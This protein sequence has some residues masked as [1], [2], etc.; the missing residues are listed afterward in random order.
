MVSKQD[1]YL[2]LSRFTMLKPFHLLE[3]C[4]W[5]E[6]KNESGEI[7]VFVAFFHLQHK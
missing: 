2:N 6:I 3:H 7:R 4:L 5:S 1:C